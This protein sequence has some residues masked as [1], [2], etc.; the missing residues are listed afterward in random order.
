MP[1]ISPMSALTHRIRPPAQDS[2]NRKPLGK[3]GSRS[4]RD[5]YKA[6]HPAIGIAGRNPLPGS[7]QSKQM[8]GGLGWSVHIEKRGED[9]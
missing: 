8:H 2:A 9:L 4:H 3:F 5:L 1:M 6:R 7:L